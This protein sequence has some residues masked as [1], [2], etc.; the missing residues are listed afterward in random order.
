MGS[1]GSDEDLVVDVSCNRQSGQLRFSC[2]ISRGDGEVLLETPDAIC[3]ELQ[4]DEAFVQAW[5]Q[6]I[7]GF[8]HDATETVGDTMKALYAE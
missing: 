6:D 1:P 3:A 5:V 8:L 2:D 4:C 7:V